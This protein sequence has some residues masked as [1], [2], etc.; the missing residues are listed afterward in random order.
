MKF[1]TMWLDR[2]QGEG[3]NLMKEKELNMEEKPSAMMKVATFIV[4][5]R[6]LFFLLFGIAVIFSLIAANWVKVEKDS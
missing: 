2:Q 5:R 3:D 6:N 1:Q 4:D